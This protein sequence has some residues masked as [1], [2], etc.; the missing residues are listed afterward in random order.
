[1]IA[2]ILGLGACKNPDTKDVDDDDGAEL[3]SQYH[4]FGPSNDTYQAADVMACCGEAWDYQYVDVY[5]EHCTYDVIQQ[6]CISLAKRLE[7]YILDG[8]FAT[9]SGQAGK[10]QS[11]IAENYDECFNTLRQNDSNPDPAALESSWK[12]PNSPAWGAIENL[13]LYI[14]AGTESTG[15]FRPESSQDWISCN[16]ANGNN[17]EV[18][19]DT[20]TT[21][22]VASWV[23]SCNNLGSTQCSRSAGSQGSTAIARRSPRR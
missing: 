15:V 1:V 11:W 6:V 9:H 12:I 18:F 21:S 20:S 5:L 23:R 7:S 13:V 8:A 19:K 16:G 14:D 4:V 10:L 17:D 3:C 2:S 22:R